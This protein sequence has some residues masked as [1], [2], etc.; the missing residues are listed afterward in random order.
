MA[1]SLFASL[2]R[3]IPKMAILIQPQKDGFMSEE[4]N[5]FHKLGNFQ[6]HI[7][8]FHKAF[9]THKDHQIN[10]GLH[11]F[12]GGCG[13]VELDDHPFYSQILHI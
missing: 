2:P 13:S 10:I 3:Q 4:G 12:N 6:E 9:N 11:M 8:E 5:N 7:H 1:K